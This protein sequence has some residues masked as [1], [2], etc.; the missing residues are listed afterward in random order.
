MVFF[1]SCLLTSVFFL[2]FKAQVIKIDVEYPERNGEFKVFAFTD[3]EKDGVLHNGFEIELEGDLRFFVDDKYKAHLISGTEILV[4]MPSVNFSFLYET[5]Q[6]M[7]HVTAF[8][9]Y[10]QRTAEARAVTRN[11][12]L[13]DE[14]RQ[15]KFILLR[16]PENIELS[17]Q[18][19]SADNET[20]SGEIESK[21]IPIQSTFNFHG[22][23]Y[24]KTFASIIWR[25]SI[26]E[27]KKRDV[28]APTVNRDE[29]SNLSST[30]SLGQS[31][32]FKP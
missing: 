29:R 22:R 8:N 25:V 27:N 31:T 12:I 18:H 23:T 9:M 14:S 28:R 11:M 24:G 17:N 32:L 3:Q 16:F 1:R 2:L 6:Y 5:E 19:Y 13:N 20:D 26:V 15:T 4:E 21:I 10:Y 7:E 30:P